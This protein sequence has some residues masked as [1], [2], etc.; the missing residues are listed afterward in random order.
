MGH[1]IP[2]LV[3]IGKPVYGYLSDAFWYDVGSTE[4]YEKLSPKLVEET[5][6]Y[7]F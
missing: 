5:F 6:S 1:V 4:A 2:H 3:R 7:L